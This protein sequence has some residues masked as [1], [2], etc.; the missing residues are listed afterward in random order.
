MK[1][2]NTNTNTLLGGSRWTFKS[3]SA[4]WVHAIQGKQGEAVEEEDFLH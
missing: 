1:L 3:R 2:L 4:D